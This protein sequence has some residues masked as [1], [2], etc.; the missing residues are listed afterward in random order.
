MIELKPALREVR[1][2]PA[3]NPFAQAFEALMSETGADSLIRKACDV[4]VT[5]SC[6]VFDASTK[7][8]LLNHHRKSRSW[9]QFGGHLE[10]EDDS[11]RS[12]ALR[13]TLEESGL[14][15]VNWLSPAPIDLH[16][17]DL[18][19]AFGRCRRHYDVVFAASASVSDVPQ[20]S[21]ESIAVSWFPLSEL[22]ADLMPDLPSR[23]PNLYEVATTMMAAEHASS[24]VP[25]I[26]VWDEK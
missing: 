20:V 21:E 1:S 6:L 15:Q 18:S 11:L 24:S 5:A 12:A 26:G 2:A 16:V 23:L 19:G 25:R 8:V 9:G 14:R 22:P 7:S 10:P 3:P 17:H 13:E 4:H